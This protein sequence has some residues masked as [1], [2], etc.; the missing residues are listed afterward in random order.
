[1]EAFEPY[2]DGKKRLLPKST[3]LAFYNWHTQVREAAGRAAAAS[4]PRSSVCPNAT[5][6]SRR[7]AARSPLQTSTSNSSP[8]FQV[9]AENETGLLFKNKRDR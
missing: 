8:N 5:P 4:Q 7:G 1:M 9:I 3:D 6:H 2:F